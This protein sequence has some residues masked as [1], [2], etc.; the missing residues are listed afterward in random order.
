MQESRKKRI[1]LMRFLAVSWMIMIFGFSATEGNE[2][3]ETSHWV[4][5]AIGRVFVSGF[6]EMSVEEQ[7]EW[8]DRI[9]YP[10]RKAA[11]ASEY[12]VLAILIF[13]ALEE[14]F[15]DK[16]KYLRYLTSLLLTALYAGS[17]EFH[18]LFVPGRAGTLFDVGVDTMGATVG[19]FILWL[20]RRWILR[21]REK[22]APDT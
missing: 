3:S 4:G 10:I 13:F 11:H 21:R 19:L 14:T 15:A 16:G 6:S 12:A 1:W 8:A 17:D 7:N 5:R 18:Q 20:I 22:K 2:S 9:D